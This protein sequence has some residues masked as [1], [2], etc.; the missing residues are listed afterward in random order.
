MSSVCQGCPSHLVTSYLLLIVPSAATLHDY[1]MMSY[2]R[3]LETCL[4]T[5][6]SRC[7]RSVSCEASQGQYGMHSNRRR[8]HAVRA[9]P[10]SYQR[11]YRQSLSPSPLLRGTHDAKP[12]LDVFLPSLLVTHEQFEGINVSH[13]ESIIAASPVVEVNKEVCNYV[14]RGAVEPNETLITSSSLSSHCSHKRSA[15]YAIVQP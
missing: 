7:E 2:V 10:R 8:L 4:A 12:L 1:M 13:V 14:V 9:L 6:H 11:L 3:A 15:L 5:P